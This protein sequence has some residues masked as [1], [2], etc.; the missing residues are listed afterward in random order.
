MRRSTTNAPTMPHRPPTT[1]AATRPRTKNSYR[2][3][4]SRKPT[5]A[6]AGLC[7]GGRGMML[8]VS[9]FGVAVLIGDVAKDAELIGDQHQLTF[10]HDNH[11]RSVRGF[12]DGRRSEEHTSELQSPPDL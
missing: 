11:L 5:M 1:V 6:S 3:G 4:S 8:V 7:D 9:P 12:Q 2:K 10:P